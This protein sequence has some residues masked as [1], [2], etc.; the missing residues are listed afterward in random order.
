MSFFRQFR[1]WKFMRMWKK[2]IKQENR[3]TA[4]NS[5]EEKLFIL[6]DFFGK[7]LFIHRKQM[8]EMQNNYKFVD[9]C[10]TGDVKTLASFA[11]A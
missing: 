5:L 6:K 3:T 11:A 2:T 7:H 1:K 9:V 4:T 8:I 10:Q